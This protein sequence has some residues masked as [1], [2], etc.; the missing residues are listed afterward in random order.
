MDYSPEYIIGNIDFSM[1]MEDMPLTG[2]DKT[3]LRNCFSGKDD[4]NQVLRET[5]KKHTLV[6]V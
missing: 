4:I 2:A 5:I 1:K 6:G 3:R